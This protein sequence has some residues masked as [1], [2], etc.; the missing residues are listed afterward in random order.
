MNVEAFQLEDSLEFRRLQWILKS[1][2]SRS[3]NNAAL[4]SIT[5]S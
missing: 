2:G 3:S 4:C 1:A 5:K